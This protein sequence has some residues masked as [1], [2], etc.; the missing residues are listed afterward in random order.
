MLD[1]PWWVTP[2]D[3]KAGDTVPIGR[4]VDDST[5]PPTAHD[6]TYTLAEDAPAGTILGAGT[7]RRLHRLTAANARRTRA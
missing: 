2:R 3:L 5:R 1:L 7:D 6:V 4:E